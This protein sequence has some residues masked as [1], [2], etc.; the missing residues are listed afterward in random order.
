MSS[1]QTLSRVSSMETFSDEAK[2]E[3][4]GNFASGEFFGDFAS[5]EYLETSPH[6]NSIQVIMSA[7]PRGGG[8][9]F[10]CGSRLRRRWRQ[11]SLFEELHLRNLWLDSDQTCMVT[12]P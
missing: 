8:N 10:W 11:R 3:F 6:V 4:S 1:L 7:P 2:V 9:Y 12:S 5:G